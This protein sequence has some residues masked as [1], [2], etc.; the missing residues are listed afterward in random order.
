MLLFPLLSFYLCLA[1][2]VSVPVPSS[3]SR[4]LLESSLMQSRLLLAHLDKAGIPVH[5]HGREP[6]EPAPSCNNCLDEVFNILFVLHHRGEN[7]VYCHKCAT[8][9][10]KSFTVL[11]QV[12]PCVQEYGAFT[13]V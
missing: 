9:L 5:W 13:P 7:L 2:I 4:S 1:F 3:F 12:K 8:A 6:G 11:Q 10:K